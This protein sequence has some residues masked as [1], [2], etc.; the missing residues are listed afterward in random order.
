[1]ERVVGTGIWEA[2]LAGVAEGALYKYEI[3]TQWGGRKLVKADPFARATE[4]PPNT[5]SRVPTRGRYAWR[6]AR[7]IKRRAERQSR[8]APISIYEV[9]LGSWRPDRDPDDDHL[10]WP[11]Y[12]SLATELVPYAKDLG[13][14][15]L[16]LMPVTEHPYDGSWGYQA[17][18]YFAPT[19]RYGTPDEFRAFVDAAHSAG[20]GVILDWVPGHFPRDAHGLAFF[21]GTHLFEP[22]DPRRGAHPDWGTLIFDF[23]RPEVVSF[24]V[25]SAVYWLEEFHVDGLRVDAVASMLYL[26]YSRKPGEWIPNRRG[27]RENLDAVAFLRR[28]NEVVHRR[29]PGVLT[30]AEESTSWPKVTTSVEKGGLGFD[31][32]WN[33]GWMNDTLAYFRCDPIVRGREHEKLSFSLTYAFTE[34]FLLPLSHD[35]VVHGKASL[36]AKMPGDHEIH[37]ANLR[38]LFGFMFTHPGKKLLFMGGEFGQWSEWSHERSLEWDL[39]Q[40]DEHRRLQDLVRALNRLYRRKPALHEVDGDWKGFEWLD[41]EDRD[42]SVL[43]FLRRAI[44]SE[45]WLVVAANFTPVTWKRYR[46]GVPD[47]ET[48]RVAFNTDAAKFGGT[49]AKLPAYVN[50]EATPHAGRSHSLV[51]DLPPLAVVVLEPTKRPRRRAK[52]QLA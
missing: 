46:V 51:F 33:M 25:S 23:E 21:D 24:L 12:A 13:F 42:R 22:A 47:A 44:D 17:T 39:L 3:R 34:S 18:G 28:L 45:D 7:W 48:Y 41:V 35:E 32:K 36:L 38:A 4:L 8:A 30:C 40:Y 37:F 1:M 29:F 50:P 6:D 15:H 10:R 27:G 43:S 20:L 26:D 52:R 31:L 14:T 49:G 2:E 5:A 19:S 16:E 11:S 9:H